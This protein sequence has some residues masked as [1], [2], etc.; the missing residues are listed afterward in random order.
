[1]TNKEQM[2][3]IDINILKKIGATPTD[4]YGNLS[5]RIEFPCTVFDQK[6]IEHKLSVLSFRKNVP[7]QFSDSERPITEVKFIKESEF[8]VP[9]DIRREYFYG[10]EISN[11]FYP[12]YVESPQGTLYII[13]H[14]ANIIE[15][16]QEN[17]SQLRL[18]QHRDF[19]NV[20]S[21]SKNVVYF[22][23]TWTEALEQLR[24]NKS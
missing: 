4:S 13:N 8:A 16:N 3:N 9:Q 12:T 11:G 15:L 18:S 21:D 1:M 2:Q 6:N 14:T 20:I 23:G 5:D 10:S 22:I 19:S 7:L 24:L 17:T